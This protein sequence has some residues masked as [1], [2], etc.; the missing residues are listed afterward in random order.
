MLLEEL[1]KELVE[2]TASLVGGRTVNIMNTEGTIVA[3]SDAARVGTFH[4]GALEAARTG[5]PVSIRP[6]QL[7]QYPGAREG[8]N[9][10]LRVSGSI[11]GVVGL[12]GDPSEI[13]YLARLLEVYA[14]K[15]YQLEAIARPRL[16]EGELRSRLLCFLLTPTDD[17][18]ARAQVLMDSMKLRPEFPLT[19][20]VISFQNA[21]SAMEQEHL[22]DF[23][24][25][26]S[27]LREGRDIWGMVN[28]RLV[29][30]RG[31]DS[32]AWA[33]LRQPEAA[34]FFLRHRLSLSDPCQG[35]WD[36]HS[37]YEQASTL[38]LMSA[39]S[40][41]DIRQLPTRCDYMLYTTSVSWA[42]FVDVLYQKLLA[43]FHGQE[44]A[45]VLDTV[46]CYYEYGRSV[47]RAADMLFIHKNTLQYRVRRLMEALELT[48]CTGFQQEYLIRLLLEHHKRMQGTS[49][50]AG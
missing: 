13:Q 34:E 31:G 48:K 30:L 49:R 17:S 42:D 20:A 16:A 39:A 38:D 9:M 1:A 3:S 50:P 6:D 25:S 15:Y 33:C 32:S 36:I 19:V 40:F 26:R 37:R 43:S 24:A 21:V 11:I 22:I 23:L 2:V 28:D 46:R 45:A 29:L 44:L 7:D 12:Y 35:L 8:C 4:Q 27:L 41:N 14:A 10:P 18:L 5:R 47:S